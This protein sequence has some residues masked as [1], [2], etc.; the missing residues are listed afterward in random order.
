MGLDYSTWSFT[1]SGHGKSVA[2]GIGGAVKRSLDK[3]VAY[4]ND[5]SN[6]ERAVEI[7][8]KCMKS[9]KCLY[10]INSDI[11]NVT[12]LVLKDLT[13]LTGTMQIH[14]IIAESPGI[15]QYRPLSCFFG[16]NRGAIVLAY[17]PT[18][19]ES[20]LRKLN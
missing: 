7:L 12:Q 6:G 10:I 8:S 5:V 9:V 2:D 13:P 20:Q 17:I 18:L 3:Q 11:A 14:Q 15:I 4:G 16:Y 19:M 1:E